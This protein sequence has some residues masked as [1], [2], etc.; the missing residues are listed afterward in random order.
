MSCFDMFDMYA[1]ESHGHDTALTNVSQKWIKQMPSFTMI[2]ETSMEARFKPLEVP[3][4]QLTSTLWGVS[5]CSVSL[6]VRQTQCGCDVVS[7]QCVQSTDSPDALQ[8]KSAQQSPSE[9]FSWQHHICTL[10]DG[11]ADIKLVQAIIQEEIL[12]R[13]LAYVRVQMCPLRRKDF[14]LSTRAIF[15]HV[16]SDPT[17]D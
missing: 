15:A 12:R 2:I 4:Y 16:L 14:F 13:T 9:K 6:L 5:A 8:L 17:N 11:D 10:K 3:F 7:P 1:I